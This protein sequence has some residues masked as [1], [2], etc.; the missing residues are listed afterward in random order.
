MSQSC[1][2]CQAEVKNSASTCNVCGWSFD[3][4]PQKSAVAVRPAAR[5]KIQA[6]VEVA[7]G[8]DRTASSNQFATG[9]PGTAELVL[10]QLEMKARKV[11]CRVQTHGDQDEGQMPILVVEDATADQAIDEIKRIAYEG[12]GDPPEHHLDAIEHLLNTTPWSMDPSR[13]RGA[14]LAFLTADTKLATT[15]STAAQIGK[16]VKDQ[17]VLLY[18]VC[19]PTPTLREMVEAADGLMFEITNEPNAGELQVIAGKLAAS[20]VA[21]VG[22][23]AT[24]P[25]SPE[26]A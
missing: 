19:Q 24:A 25:I 22:S 2:S 4:Q 12:G 7:F 20:I 3:E 9:I 8:I 14:I 16:K 23:G 6:E 13:A 10:R 1:P 26:N 17:G 15:G 5:P 18:L 21:T 11:I